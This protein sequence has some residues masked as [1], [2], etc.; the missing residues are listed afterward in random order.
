[1]A[2]FKGYYAG[3]GEPDVP[4]DIQLLM[5]KHARTMQRKGYILRSDASEGSGES[6]ESA[7]TKSEIFLPW[8]DFRNRRVDNERYFLWSKDAI[9]LAAKYHPNWNALGPSAKKLYLR[10]VHVMLGKDLQTPVDFVICWTPDG[11]ASGGTGQA[12]RIAEDYGI[13]VFNL[14]KNKEVSI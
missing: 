8:D 12:L 10:M 2:K 9:P 5:Q 13:L 11:K 7:L 1:L 14:R 3:I 4:S 6:F